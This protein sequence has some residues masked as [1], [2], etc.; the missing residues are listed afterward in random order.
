VT[1]E[2]LMTDPA[3]NA[4]VQAS[5]D[6][7]PDY[8]A[9]DCDVEE[10]QAPGLDGADPVAVRVYTPTG[11]APTAALV[12]SHGGGWITGSLDQREADG[13][14][15]ELATRAQALVVSVGYRLAN[16]QDVTYPL[17][18][19]DVAAAFA[20]TRQRCQDLGL[21]PARV[22]LGGASAGASLAFSAT[23]EALAEGTPLPGRLQLI[24]PLVH[25][26]LPEADTAHL[27]VLPDVLRLRQPLVDQLIGAYL[28]PN[29]D[30]PYFE[31][32]GRDTAELPPALVVVSE[33]DDLR[34][35]GE[36]LTRRIQEDGGEVTSYLAEGTIHGHLSL[37]GTAT[38]TERTLAVMADYLRS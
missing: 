36:D 32:G 6:I 37:S 11:A 28:G 38:E 25:R 30:A 7:D 13:V 24:Y 19:R 5:Y 23:L 1:F 27:D 3:V 26:V 20:W 33:Y 35:S 31:L 14:A 8:H 17:L 2:Q 10:L 34:P 12:W 16:G 9:P 22:Q 29:S 4:R 18:H 15:R 21:D